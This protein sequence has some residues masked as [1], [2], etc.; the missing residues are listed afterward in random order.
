VVIGERKPVAAVAATIYRLLG[1][2]R[3]DR[4]GSEAIDALP[5]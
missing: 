1:I 2:V 3:P 5:R 4:L